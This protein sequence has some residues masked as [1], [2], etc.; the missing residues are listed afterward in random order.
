MNNWDYNGK[1]YMVDGR[2]R[3]NNTVHLSDLKYGIELI[4]R[5]VEVIDMT[6]IL[7]PIGMNFPHAKSEM[8]RILSDLE[9]E[10]QGACD[11]ANNIRRSLSI[12]D[13]QSSGYTV[14]AVI[15]ESHITIHTFP[16]YG[17]FTFD[18][19]SCKDFPHEKVRALLN[20]YFASDV[21]VEHVV[22]RSIPQFEYEDVISNTL[23]D[24]EGEG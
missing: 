11:T 22:F 1:H 14:A 21:L 2:R 9:K 4:N 5:I 6:L 8:A 15:A 17:W 24:D 10:G 7:P 23:D 13:T 3:V 18:C 16:E 20:E 12:R 19:Y